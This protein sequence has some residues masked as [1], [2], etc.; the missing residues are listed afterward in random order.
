[1]WCDVKKCNHNRNGYCQNADYISIDAHG[2]C[3]SNTVV[4]DSSEENNQTSEEVSLFDIWKKN[5]EERQKEKNAGQ[6]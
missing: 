2:K 4:E 5:R 6:I 1:M 3:D